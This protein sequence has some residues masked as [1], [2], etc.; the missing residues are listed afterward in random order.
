MALSAFSSLFLA[1]PSKWGK[2]GYGH[3]PIWGTFGTSVLDTHGE[4]APTYLLLQRFKWRRVQDSET[5]SQAYIHLSDLETSISN[6]ELKSLEKTR[7][8]CP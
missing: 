2:A 5:S 7:H 4:W 1:G 6:A 3:G 8:K